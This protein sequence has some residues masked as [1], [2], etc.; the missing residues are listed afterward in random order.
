MENTKPTQAKPMVISFNAFRRMTEEEK[1]ILDPELRMA[2]EKA[3]TLNE[4]KFIVIDKVTSID[5]ED[6]VNAALDKGYRF[7]S[8]PE[9]KIN[10]HT[11]TIDLCV[12]T[13]I[14]Q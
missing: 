1:A 11:H 4:P 13:M 6:A 7:C 8:S 14:K 2:L 12:V 3:I 9:I 10:E 5:F